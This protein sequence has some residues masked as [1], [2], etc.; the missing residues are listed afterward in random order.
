MNA[1]PKIKILPGMTLSESD[2]KDLLEKSW[3]SRATAE[4]AGLRRFNDDEAAEILRREQKYSVCYA[5]IGFPFRL[6]ESDDIRAWH[7]RLDNPP[8]GPDGREEHKYL[9]PPGCRNMFYFP[10]SLTMAEL[11]DNSLPLVFVEGEKK[12]LALDDL[13]IFETNRRRWITI[14]L[15][16]VWNWRGVGGRGP[17]TKG[18]RV[19]QKGPIADW[20][21]F[22][23]G[24]LDTRKV[25][26]CFDNDV[27]K[28]DQVQ[29][30]RKALSNLLTELGARV[31]WVEVPPVPV[32]QGIDDF[33]AEHGPEAALVLFSDA[34][35]RAEY[36]VPS[37]FRVN[38]HGV[39]LKPNP[40]KTEI[41][42]RTCGS[43]VPLKYPHPL[44]IHQERIG[45][46]CWNGTTARAG[47]IRGRCRWSY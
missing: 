29:N 22:P 31:R 9:F 21:L 19:D 1:Q 18:K 28:N 45:A 30:A 24:A 47:T 37:E 2:Y 26:I 27:F 32:K 38:E 15:T 36:E 7:I 44:A 35:K 43:A 5:G 8:L 25:I 6:P 40:T 14:G 34:E 12:A 39:W 13:A 3:I 11:A 17:N 46:G 23:D 33:I 42:G 4:A 20:G 10:P 41:P 16:G